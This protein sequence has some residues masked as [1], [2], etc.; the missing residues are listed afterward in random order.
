MYQF[1][2]TSGLL[3]TFLASV[4]VRVL[5]VDSIVNEH[6]TLCSLSKINLKYVHFKGKSNYVEENFIVRRN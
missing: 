1:L 4:L 5:K 6:M 2:T 3:F